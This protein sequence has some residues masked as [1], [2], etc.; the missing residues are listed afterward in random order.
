LSVQLEL[1]SAPALKAAEKEG[2][3]ILWVAVSYS[4]YMETDIAAYQAANNPARP[5]DALSPSALN[6]ELVKIAQKIREATTRPITLRQEGSRQ[7]IPPQTST[8]PLIPK[9]PFEP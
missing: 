3:T 5:L 1:Q 9:Q 6:E 2:L 7:S 4:L 8:K